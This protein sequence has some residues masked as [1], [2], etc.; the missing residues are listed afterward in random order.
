MDRKGDR[1]RRAES[2]IEGV[3]QSKVNEM[4]VVDH[5]A[6]LCLPL[7]L[8]YI[9]DEMPVGVQPP[10]ADAKL[11]SRLRW[12]RFARMHRVQAADSRAT[13]GH[14]ALSRSALQRGAAEG[15]HRY[16]S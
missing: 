10:I 8:F 14:A 7:S 12:Q 6:A 2:R 13:G 3:G 15:Q 11:E 4:R 16:T 5:L 9:S 1:Q